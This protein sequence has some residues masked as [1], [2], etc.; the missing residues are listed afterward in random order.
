MKE[1]YPPLSHQRLSGGAS[2]TTRSRLPIHKHGYKEI[3]LSSV[4]ED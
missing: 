2:V 3:F 4:G 1:K